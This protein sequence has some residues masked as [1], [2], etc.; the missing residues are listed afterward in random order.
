M[1]SYYEFEVSLK[2]IAPRI[3]RRFL[4]HESATFEDLHDAIQDSFG[5]ERDHMWKFHTAGRDRQVLCVGPAEAFDIDDDDALDDASLALAEVFFTGKGGRRKCHYTYDF[6]DNWLHEVSWVRKVKRD[7][8]FGRELLGGE[9]AGPLEDW[10][11][12][13]GY[14]QLLELIS[15][16]QD[17]DDPELAERLEWLSGWDPERFDLQKERRSFD[18]RPLKVTPVNPRL[19]PSGDFDVHASPLNEDGERKLQKKSRKQNR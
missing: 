5:W 19:V 2:H 11:G 12:P 8:A 3:W 18:N 6:G 7:D 10:G 14:D 9:R 16:D 17:T 4:L 13:W 15:G 1:P